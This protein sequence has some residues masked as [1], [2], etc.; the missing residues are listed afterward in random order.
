MEP[1]DFNNTQ[2][3]RSLNFIFDNVEHQKY[4]LMKC[5]QNNDEHGILKNIRIITSEIYSG[6][7]IINDML[8]VFCRQRFRGTQLKN[9]FNSNFKMIYNKF[10]KHD[11]NMPAIYSDPFICSFYLSAKSWFVDIHDIRTQET[12]YGVGW[13]QKD[14]KDLLYVNHNRNGTSKQI[15]TNPSELIK[16]TMIEFITLVD[17][18]LGI[19]TH[20]FNHLNIKEQ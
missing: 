1:I 6:C 4:D 12:H 17:G 14:E 16:L 2:H 18:F 13:I 10:A 11:K 20:I 5:V 15:Y 19:K 3:V 7:D 8:I 9:G